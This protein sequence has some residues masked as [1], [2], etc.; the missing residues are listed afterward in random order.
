MTLA[1]KA[2]FKP[3]WRHSQHFRMT[4]I[5]LTEMSET[6]ANTRVMSL[7][8]DILTFSLSDS[9]LTSF[10]MT[11]PTSV[12]AFI[13]G[14]ERLSCLSLLAGKLA[15]WFASTEAEMLTGSTLS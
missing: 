1:T 6:N 13:P 4:R 8:E 3:F 9:G 15:S 12:G 10:N 2:S 14:W 5:F 11:A 7:A